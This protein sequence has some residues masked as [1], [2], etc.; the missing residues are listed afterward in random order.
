M[1]Y[2]KFIKQ[3]IEDIPLNK[4]VGG[5]PDGNNVHSDRYMCLDNQRTITLADGTKTYN[6]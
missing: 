3:W 6:L 2:K 1:N 5:V 4:L